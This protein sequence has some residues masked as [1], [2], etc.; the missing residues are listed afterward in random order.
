MFPF[1]V[2]NLPRYVPAGEQSDAIRFNIAELD[3]EHFVKL[4]RQEDAKMDEF[5]EAVRPLMD[6]LSHGCCILYVKIT[7]PEPNADSSFML[8]ICAW[9]GRNSIRPYVARNEKAHLLRLCGE[10]PEP[11]TVSN[12]KGCH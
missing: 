10:E 9:K 1:F 8:P 12:K 5:S 3:A 6:L 2:R 4:L 11:V 7:R